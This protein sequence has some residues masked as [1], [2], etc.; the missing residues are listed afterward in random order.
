MGE[1]P[2]VA[3]TSNYGERQ[4]QYTV[5]TKTSKTTETNFADTSRTKVLRTKYFQLEK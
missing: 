1:L 3:Y 4:V 2:W 5:A